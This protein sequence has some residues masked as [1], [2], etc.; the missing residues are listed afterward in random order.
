MLKAGTLDRAYKGPIDCFKRV[1]AEEGVGPLW[2]GNVANCLRYFP[3]QALN[4]MF[5]D[6]LTSYVFIFLSFFLCFL[7]FFFCPRTFF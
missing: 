2:R 4:F 5:K 7:F 1:I 6:M 3:T